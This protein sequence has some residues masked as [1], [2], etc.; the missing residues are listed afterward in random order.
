MNKKPRRKM[1]KGAR[2]GLA[3]LSDA[4]HVRLTDETLKLTVAINPANATGTG[5]LVP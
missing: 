3:R 2:L 4:P 5:S 1:S